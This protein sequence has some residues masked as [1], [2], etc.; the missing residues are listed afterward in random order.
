MPALMLALACAGPAQAQ[1]PAA[2]QSLA[3]WQEAVT[4]LLASQG[5]KMGYAVEKCVLRPSFAGAPETYLARGFSKDS[6]TATIVLVAVKDGKVSEW[7][8]FE[9]PG[10]EGWITHF[11]RDCKGSRLELRDRRVVTHR[12]RWDGQSFQPLPVKGKGKRRS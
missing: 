7:K 5:D 11:N 4:T 1:E 12:Y 9:L 8:E 10:F 2:G 3:Q 6:T